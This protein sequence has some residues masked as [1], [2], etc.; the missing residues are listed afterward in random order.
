MSLFEMEETKIRPPSFPLTARINQAIT[1]FYFEHFVR[2]YL[3]P[4]GLE[5]RV[6]STLREAD[7]N[8]AVGGAENS[9]HVHGLAVDF[10]LFRAG[11]RVP[12]AEESQIF[13]DVIAPHW[14]G[15]ALD[16]VK[17]KNHIHLNL[18]RQIS[19][20]T[21]ITTAAVMG[22]I[23]IPIFKR[24]FAPEKKGGRR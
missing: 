8:A 12:A 23:A 24:L 10:Q 21:G 16:E 7:H 3:A 4:L 9:A 19:V 1:D 17:S 15:F 22:M 11:K 20:S 5:A 18:T 2:K 13:R 14:S 6:T